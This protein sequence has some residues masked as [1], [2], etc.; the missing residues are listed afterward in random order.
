M[1]Y[2]IRETGEVKNQGEIRRLHSR[3]SFPRVWNPEICDAIGIDPVLISPKPEVS[4]LESAR[5]D[6]AIEDGLGNWVENWI[7]SDTFSDYTDRDDVLH[8]KEDQEVAH[9]LVILNKAKDYKLNQIK[10]LFTDSLLNGLT[11]S[12]GI[13]LDI[14]SL[15]M[16]GATLAEILGETEMMIR[17]FDNEMHTLPLDDVKVMI[18]ELSL[19]K[20]TLW[21]NKVNKQADIKAL[22]SLID[23]AEYDI[24]LGWD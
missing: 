9:S 14:S 1:K 3:T 2:R 15:I 13:K 24:S 12:S 17:D 11:T 8:T 16:D 7:V 5:L 20:R 10:V 23:V 18:A 6:G 22:S 21:Y 19:T 4:H